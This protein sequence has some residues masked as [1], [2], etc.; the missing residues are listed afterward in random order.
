MRRGG[1]FFPAGV[2]VGVDAQYFLLVGAV[3]IDGVL[4]GVAVVGRVAARLQRFKFR[5]HFLVC[6][7]AAGLYGTSRRPEL[8]QTQVRNLCV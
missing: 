4:E 1:E 5:L 6:R 7:G 8:T 2:V 3:A